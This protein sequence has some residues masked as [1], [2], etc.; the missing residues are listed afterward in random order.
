M[1]ELLFSVMSV[2][3]FSSVVTYLCPSGPI[4]KLVKGA[5]AIC[6]CAALLSPFSVLFGGNADI[7]LPDSSKPEG[8]RG[9]AVAEAVCIRVERELEYVLASDFGIISPTVSLVMDFSDG[10]TIKITE[11]QL[12]G[13]GQ[14]L[15]EGAEYLNKLLDC[16]V[17]VKE[18]K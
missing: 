16:P 4:L 10:S 6:V 11:A 8:V 15:K 5:C 9:E 17:T 12:S 18:T 1:R 14:G 13:R 7:S 3:L 2:S